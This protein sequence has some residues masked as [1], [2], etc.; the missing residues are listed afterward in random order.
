M[1]PIVCP[2]G[3]ARRGFCADATRS[4][5]LF[6][7]KQS[8]AFCENSLKLVVCV[9]TALCGSRAHTF[10]HVSPGTGTHTQTLITAHMHPYAQPLP[11]PPF[12]ASAH[13]HSASPCAGNHI[14][15]QTHMHACA[16]PPS[17]RASPSDSLRLTPS[18]E[19]AP[20]LLS[21][22]ALVRRRLK[23]PAQTRQHTHAKILHLCTLRPSVR[24]SL[25]PSLPPTL[26]PSLPLSHLLCLHPSPSLRPLPSLCL[27]L[28]SPHFGAHLCAPSLCTGSR[29]PP[30]RRLMQPATTA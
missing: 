3:G 6:S 7:P 20:L 16:L 21:L 28:A 19:L 9:W 12:P 22:C 27:P 14:F 30:R 1:V 2:D 25:P 11:L 17:L 23:Q 8:R 10:A 4:R 5:R 18:R 15:T 29:L 13:E 24:P 26:P